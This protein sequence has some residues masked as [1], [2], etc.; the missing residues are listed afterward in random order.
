LLLSILIQ[1]RTALRNS[2]PL[3]YLAIG[4]TIALAVLLV[5]TAINRSR[6]SKLMA[7]GD[8]V[9][10]M[11]RPF[12]A[13]GLGALYLLTFVGVIAVTSVLKGD[14]QIELGAILTSLPIW[15]IGFATYQT[16]YVN[17]RK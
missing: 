15:A 7:N 4:V 8:V 1:S 17:S 14:S 11:V 13:A 12:N 9:D 3:I 2:D 16:S 10:F 6:T 5:V